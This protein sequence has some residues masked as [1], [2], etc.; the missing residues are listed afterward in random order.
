MTV[1]KYFSENKNPTEQNLLED[2]AIEI[3]QMAGTDI[4]Y[5][6][7][8]MINND[9]IL[10]ENN[11]ALFEKGIVIE[12]Y[13]NNADNYGGQGYFIGQ[14]GNVVDRTMSFSISKKRFKQEVKM[15]FPKEGDLIYVPWNNALFQIDYVEHETNFYQHQ[16]NYLFELKCSL[17][18]ASYEE[19]ETEIDKVDDQLDRDI[20]N[21][22]GYAQNEEIIEESQDI[23]DFSEENPLGD[24]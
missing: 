8:N 7:R 1:S 24:L 12:A 4:K 6:P 21:D 3:I 16:K 18:T 5:I 10:N 22:D 15:D 2:I 20:L 23:L 14:F 19:F 9:E 11:R 13:L 17:F